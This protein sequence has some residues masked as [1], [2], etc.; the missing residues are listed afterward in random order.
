MNQ[1]TRKSFIGRN[2]RRHICR[3]LRPK[4]DVIIVSAWAG[5]IS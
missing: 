2:G 3:P 1:V 5:A 4:A